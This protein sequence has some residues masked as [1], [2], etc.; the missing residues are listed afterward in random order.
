MTEPNLERRLRTALSARAATVTA[1]DLRPG[2][3]PAAARHAGARRWLPVAAGLAAAAV[4]VT[5]FALLRPADP[6]PV[7]PVA[8]ASPSVPAPTSASASAPASAS[9]SAPASSPAASPAGSPTLPRGERTAGPDPTASPPA[10]T[11]PP[12]ASRPAST[13]AP[14]PR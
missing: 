13:V 14:T 1:A 7:Q 12:T 11:A 4:S 3:G 9:A 2:Q 5:V 6:P 10:S 8:P